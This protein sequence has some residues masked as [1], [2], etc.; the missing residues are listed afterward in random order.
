MWYRG[1]G[2]G[3]YPCM[4]ALQ[5]LERSCDQLVVAG[6]PLANIVAILLDGCDNLAMV[7]L[8]VGLLVRHLDDAD[9]LLDPYLSEP[10]AWEF[11]FGRMVHET[12]GLAASSDG[13]AHADRRQWSLR[14]AGMW[15]VLAC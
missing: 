14:E 13:I 15:L 5:A 7:A 4:S 12:S 10:L 3:P 2:V 8:V 6:I 1:T 11:E 9:R